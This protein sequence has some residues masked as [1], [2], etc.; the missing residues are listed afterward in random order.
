MQIEGSVRA[1]LIAAI[2]SARRLRGRPVHNDTIKYWSQLLDHAR[3][4]S[5]QPQAEVFGDLMTELETE[6]AHSKAA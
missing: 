4:V 3:R 2:A 5:T 6:V 1:N